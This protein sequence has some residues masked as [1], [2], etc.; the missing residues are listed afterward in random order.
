MKLVN[1]SMD[2]LNLYESMFTDPIY[3]ADLGGVQPLEKIPTI[4][5]KQVDCSD[6]GKGWVFKVLA[7]SDDI[8]E[9][10]K[11]NADD[12]AYLQS[13]SGVGS[14]CLWDGF[15]ED[16]VV[17]EI[18]F[19]KNSM[20]C[21]LWYHIKG[22]STRFQGNGFASKALQL[23]LDKAKENRDRWGSNFTSIIIY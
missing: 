2:D 7:T 23:L 6:S 20:S 14:I 18:G 3:M 15:W 8:S 5:Q 1:V 9:N 22:I 12:I 19:G 21:L 10:S 13:N 4:L 16:K 17:T 11:F